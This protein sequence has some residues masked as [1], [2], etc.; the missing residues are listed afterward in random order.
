[1]TDPISRFML[2]TV[3]TCISHSSVNPARLRTV[4]RVAGTLSG[5]TPRSINCII[6]LRTTME[7]GGLPSL[8]VRSITGM[9]LVKRLREATAHLYRRIFS[10]E[11]FFS[12]VLHV[13]QILFVAFLACRCPVISCCL[14]S[15]LVVFLR[16]IRLCLLSWDCCAL[17][18]AMRR[19]TCRSSTSAADCKHLSAFFSCNHKDRNT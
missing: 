18:L 4:E 3:F 14:F 6:M 11:A 13:F 2:Y 10:C 16:C 8:H 12:R 17:Q 5:V 19:L 15:C 1:V 9:G 7:M